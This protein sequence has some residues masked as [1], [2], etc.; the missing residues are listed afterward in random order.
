MNKEFLKRPTIV[1][2]FFYPDAKDVLSIS[3]KTSLTA[4]SIPKVASP[5][6]LIT[7]YASYMYASR[8]FGAAYSQLINEDIDTIII[9]AP[10]HKMAFP[11]IALSESDCFSCPLGDLFVD[12]EDNEF[13][14]EQNKEYFFYGEKYHLQEH[15]IEVQLPFIYTLLGNKVKILPIILGETNTKLT[16]LLAKTLFSLLS[17]KQKK[18]LVV[19]AADLSCDLK[20]E[21]AMETDQKFMEVLKTMDADYFAEQL[22]LN[23][24]KSLGGGGVISVLRLAEMMGMKNINILKYMN[25]GDVTHDKFKVEGYLAASIY[26]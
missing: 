4:Y 26:Q 24:I 15:S 5:F 20:Y 6:A 25:S 18:Y 23:Q 22:A 8:V 12:K 16:I 7:P 11:A 1:D 3:V 17:R 13:L 14:L 21:K 9:I 19:A 10:I 2:G